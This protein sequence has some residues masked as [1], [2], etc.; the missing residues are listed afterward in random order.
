MK[1]FFLRQDSLYKIFT[2]LEKTPKNSQVQIFVE[3]DNQFFHNA[4]WSKQIDGILSKRSIQATFIAQ[5][6]HQR[7]FFEDNKINH[8]VKKESKIRIF[9]NLLYR[10]FFNIRKFHLHTYQNKNYSFVAIFGA[11][12][13]LILLVGYSIYSLILPQT[14]ITI[15]PSYEMNEIV[16]N[17][18]YMYP[19][20]IAIYPYTGK[21]IIIPLYTGTINQ[22][23]TTMWLDK[24]MKGDGSMTR[25]TIR[26]INTTSS[27]ISLKINTQ[28]IDDFGIEYTMDDK[29]SIPAAQGKDNAGTA[30]IRITSKNTP[31]NN[32]LVQENWTNITIWHRFLI[33]N[34]RQSFY[35][36]QVY[37]EASEG[38]DI[39][40]Y[41]QPGFI[42]MS[43]I[44][45]LQKNLYNDLYEKRK[46]FVTN[47]KVPQWGIIVPFNNLITVDNCDYNAIW[48]TTHLDQ[49]SVMSGS[50][51]CDIHFAYVLKEDIIN[52][53]KDYI[54][55]RSTNTRKI[56]NI[57]NN[58]INFFDI[59]TGE[60]NA[61]IIP[62]KVNVIEAYNLQHDTNNILWTLKNQ[63]VGKSKEDAVKILQT[64]PEIEK[65]DITISPFWYSSITSVKSRINIK[66]NENN[67]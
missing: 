24:K 21:H 2:T 30:Y 59:L 10:F 40:Q 67:T 56:V 26:I 9:L 14:T 43:E 31:E 4:R 13:F 20:D 37:A 65:G 15:T 55:K 22:I 61:Y 50:L 49:L 63:L 42:L 11:E 53:M 62:T 48:D 1:L 32:L 19:E 27:V 44:G 29:V 64:F 25:G 12:I 7:K 45:E 35:T 5:N 66:I 46:E 51:S 58:F 36:K 33:K 54:S 3:S 52:G 28:L 18:R 47:D 8:E 23:S 16:Y 57:Q 60:Y 34:L 39:Q 41:S 6:D 38:F 17:F